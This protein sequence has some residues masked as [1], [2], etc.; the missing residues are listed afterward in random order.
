MLVSGIAFAFG[1]GAAS[2]VSRLIGGGEAV[3]AKE[4]A[5]TSM[6]SALVLSA[7]L[8]LLIAWFHQPVFRL[9]GAD[10]HVMEQAE[11]YGLI[12]LIGAVINT[13]TVT[14]NNLIRSEGFAKIS[15]LTM[16]IGAVLNCILD[17]LFIH[18]FAWGIEGAAIATVVAQTAALCFILIA[19][20]KIDSMVK[21][22]IRQVRLD[23][24]IYREV[25]KI[26][27]PV[28]IYQGLNSLAI[29]VIN[30]QAV[31]YGAEA[32]AALGI[33]TRLITLMSYVVFGFVKGLQPV[34]GYTCGAHQYD[35]LH[36]A[37]QT[38]RGILSVYCVVAAALAVCLAPRII[39][40]FTTDP[41]VAALGIRTLILW[42]TTFSFLGFQ[43]TYVTAFLALGKAAEGSIIG[44][45]RQGVLLI[46]L[47]FLLKGLLGLD[48]LIYAQ[49]AAD[50]LTL[51]L[52]IHYAGRLTKSFPAAEGDTTNRSR[53]LLHG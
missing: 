36:T 40:L 45:S 21:L 4:V 48:G 22:S 15:M 18:T 29:A 25:L 37:I 27:I 16:S 30:N 10:A 42:S 20:R 1:T 52:T 50:L 9:F 7:I 6:Y 39:G 44:L 28:L 34:A 12:I 46:P 33:V 13:G 38:T 41:R 49:P 23:W 32:I 51:L 31:T 47:L 8:A 3:R 2:V 26:G 5:S 11:A 35:R 17:P 14:A 19:Y 43:M 53:S 24:S